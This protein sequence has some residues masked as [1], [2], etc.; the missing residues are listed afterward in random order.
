MPHWRAHLPHA[1]HNEASMRG[2]EKP[3]CEMAPTG[4]TANNGH[5]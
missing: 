3:S 5:R 2:N 1:M 4:H